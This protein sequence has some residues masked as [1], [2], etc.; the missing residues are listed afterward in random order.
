MARPVAEAV[1]GALA[2]A[3]AL[4]FL[5][6]G[7]LETHIASAEQFADAILDAGGEGPGLDLGSGG[8][9]PG[10]LLAT[11][12]ADWSWVL[13]DAHRRRTSFLASTVGRLGWAPRVA[14][15]R[16]RAEA[17]G[18][19]TRHRERYGVV[20][21]RSFGPPALTA[22]AASAFVAIGG[23]VVVA[24][25]PD[26]RPDRWDPDGLGA[27]GLEVVPSA[28]RAVCVLRKARTLADTFPRDVKRQRAHPVF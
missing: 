12:F 23:V 27:L 9:V 11:W 26:G 21:A 22:E 17:A 6:P 2:E 7:P 28:D 25:P 16:D 4:G 1:L 24:E 10:L 5:G 13:F 15:V 19:T 14:V 3:R 8:G 18:H 20:T